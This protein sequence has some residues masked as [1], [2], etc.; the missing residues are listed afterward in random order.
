[1]ALV[2]LAAGRQQGRREDTKGPSREGRETKNDMQ[3][4]NSPRMQSRQA[5]PRTMTQHFVMKDCSVEHFT[6]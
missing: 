2:A 4:V 3:K 5:V 6:Y 1:M